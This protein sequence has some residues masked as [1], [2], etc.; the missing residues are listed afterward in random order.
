VTECGGLC[1]LNVNSNCTAFGFSGKK[2]L[3]LVSNVIVADENA[4]DVKGD[5]SMVIYHSK[6]NII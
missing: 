4:T 3:C 5:N 1:L 6:Q 2:K